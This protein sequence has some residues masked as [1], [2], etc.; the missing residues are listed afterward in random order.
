MHEEPVFLRF[1]PRGFLHFTRTGSQS[2][3]FPADRHM[4][5]PA[6]SGARSVKIR[7]D[8][9][10]APT[11]PPFP[12]AR[13]TLPRARIP[14]VRSPTRAARPRRFFAR[15]RA[16]RPRA[17]PRFA[18]RAPALRRSRAPRLV[19]PRTHTRLWGEKKTCGHGGNG[20][21]ADARPR[22]ARRAR[23]PLRRVRARSD[24][25]ARAG[26]HER[27]AHHLRRRC[28]S[29]PSRADP[30]LDHVL[31]NPAR[32]SRRP[33]GGGGGGSRPPLLPA[34]RSPT[35]PTSPPPPP[36]L[37]SPVLPQRATAPSRTGSSTAT[38]SIA[39]SS[40]TPGTP[41]TSCARAILTRASSSP[42]AASGAGDRTM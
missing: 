6:R 15:R 2:S 5:T 24:R 3:P 13:S 34:A 22:L 29:R 16:T 4:I 31:A 21:R 30:V 23:A 19:P 41:A 20:A 11:P 27:G 39:P 37:L 25:R 18:P 12:P 26:P 8:A 14:F 33:T 32:S 36:S 40:S 38:P 28:A 9:S 42:T 7:G 17:R 35:P 10:R 1:R